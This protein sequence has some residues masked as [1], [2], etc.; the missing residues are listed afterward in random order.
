MTKVN[1][2]LG[3][4]PAEELEIVAVHEHIGYGMPGSELD[5][6][7][8]KTP[9]QALRG[10]R[11][12]AARSSASTAAA[13]SSTPPASATAATSTT[14]SP[15][16]RK[17]G[18]HIVACTGFVG[19]DTA[20]PLLRRAS[21]DYLAKVVHPRDHRR[22]RQHR[23]Q[24]R[25]HQGRREPRRPHDG[26]RQAHLPGRGPRRRRHR[27]ADPHPPGHRPGTG[28]DIFNE[29]GLPLDRVLFGHADDG[30]NARESP[31]T[32]GS[33]S[34]AAASA[35]TPSAT[36]S[37]CRTRRSGAATARAPRALPP[38]REQGLRST[39]C[40]SRPTPTAARWAGRA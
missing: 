28:V 37:S 18:V 22:H 35:S 4:I 1:T 5:T 32:T 26:P 30:L 24:G 38:P 6:K 19:G 10:D 7:W 16:P 27:R 3:T 2:V 14:T 29:E 23:R 12:E 25:R 34:R 8:W 33:P 31:R 20:L 13:P 17:T 11:A 39:S 36:T 40:S 9:E 15:C 21:V